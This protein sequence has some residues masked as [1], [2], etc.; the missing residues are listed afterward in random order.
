ME[1]TTTCKEILICLII[2]GWWRNFPLSV[3]SLAS[4]VGNPTLHDLVRNGTSS[5]FWL[6]TLLYGNRRLLLFE[7]T[8]EQRIRDS[9]FQEGKRR[10][11]RGLAKREAASDGWLRSTAEFRGWIILLQL[12]RPFFPTR[13]T[14]IN[15]VGWVPCHHCIKRSRAAVAERIQLWQVS[16]KNA[17]CLL[18]RSNSPSRITPR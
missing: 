13:C 6:V 4:V 14:R 9:Y 10:T 11:C 2:A 16:S 18:G 1:Y 15:Y 17:C 5:G 7:K 8:R 12:L 3:I